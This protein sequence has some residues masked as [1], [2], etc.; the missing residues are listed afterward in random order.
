MRRK[1]AA[2]G[3][4]G[5]ASKST[6][7]PKS[8]GKKAMVTR[9]T[10]SPPAVGSRDIA[11]QH[12]IYP[13]T[14]AKKSPPS[15]GATRRAIPGRGIRV[16]GEP[17]WR[18]GAHHSPGVARSRPHPVSH[19]SPPEVTTPK[20]GVS[21]HRPNT[22]AV[23]AYALSR[24]GL[25]S[26]ASDSPPG[27]MQTL[28]D[29]GESGG[30]PGGTCCEGG[31]RGGG[32]EGCRAPG[33]APRGLRARNIG[34]NRTWHH[35]APRWAVC[36][37]PPRRSAWKRSARAEAAEAARAL[38]AA[39]AAEAAAVEEREFT[40]EAQAGMLQQMSGE[41]ERAEK[42]R[43]EAER[44]KAAR[45]EKVLKLQAEFDRTAA[46]LAQKNHQM[47]QMQ[48]DAGGGFDAARR[49]SLGGGI[50]RYSL[51]DSGRRA[52]VSSAGRPS[53]SHADAEELRA[54]ESVA[55]QSQERL[56]ELVCARQAAE[57][58]AADARADAKQ[59]ET[60][61]GQRR[62]D[63]EIMQEELEGCLE[64]ERAERR[65]A[66]EEYAK[67]REKSENLERVV[68]RRAEEMYALEE[69]L[70]AATAATEQ[71]KASCEER[72]ALLRDG[73]AVLEQK[74]AEL[75][76][77]AEYALQLQ[78][79]L[80]AAR[81]EREEAR[82]NGTPRKNVARMEAKEAEIREIKVEHESAMANASR[83]VETLKRQLMERDASLA[84]A[85]R[86][87]QAHEGA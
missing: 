26:R 33:E 58:D 13:T 11:H 60:E 54:A 56:L 15:A 4:R 17:P 1:S 69:K 28:H 40:I 75:D 86:E 27:P 64:E 67:A 2:V 72:D 29:R 16:H 53:M 31:A 59:W 62:A 19:E 74:E 55:R 47:H 20:S 57:R 45:E 18:S 34:F 23:A 84:E 48:L 65:K 10:P 5:S 82:A 80:Q 42:S 73:A 68:E 50:G 8:S 83:D 76:D 21:H 78:Q 25:L 30:A 87:L 70:A 3:A 66:E 12:D 22:A 46:E 24:S 32:G 61:V 38:Q 81:A 63:I 41:L 52:S 37:P 35:S 51:G 79:Q 71:M 39:K 9:A 43:D 14:H 6:E 36:R 44:S 77:A 85:S 7:K 49:E